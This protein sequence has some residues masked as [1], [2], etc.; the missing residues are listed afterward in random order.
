MSTER[1]NDNQGT[2]RMDSDIDRMDVGTAKMNAIN[3]AKQK[4]VSFSLLDIFILFTDTP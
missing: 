1:M 2:A 3:L 4:S